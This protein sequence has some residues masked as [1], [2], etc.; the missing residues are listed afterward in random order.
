MNRTVLMNLCQITVLLCV[1]GE[2]EHTKVANVVL[3]DMGRKGYDCVLGWGE[4]HKV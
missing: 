3:K 4:A 2:G 1:M